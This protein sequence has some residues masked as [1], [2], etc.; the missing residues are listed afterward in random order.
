MSK[1]E[2]V[3]LT[4]VCRGFPEAPDPEIRREHLLDTIDKVFEGDTRLVVVEG[5]EGIGKTT[6]LAQFAKRHPENALSLF[7]KPCSRLAYSP[8]YLTVVLSEQL[9]WV[10]HKEILNEETVDQ[11]FL[12]NQFPILQRRA[13]RNREKYFFIVDGLAD[14]PSEDDRLKDIVLKDLLPLGLPG[15]YFLL[16]G[17]LR[18]FSGKI[19]RSIL[20][21]SFPL[22]PF[23]FDDTEKY[24]LDLELDRPS[25]EETYKMCGGVPGHLAIVRRMIQSG[26]DL[27][28]ILDFVP[29]KLP[30]F[31][32]IEWSKVNADE[33][34]KK[35]LAV[36]AYAQKR[37]TVDELSR[38]LGM[39]TTA[40]G[41]FLRSLGIVTIQSQDGEVCFIS[42][43]HRKY[44]ANQLQ[45]L[46]EQA[47][48][49]L[50]SDL[51]GQKESDAAITG[52]IPR[53]LLRRIYFL[54]EVRHSRMLLAG[55]Q[56]KLGLDPR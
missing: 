20:S 50:I 13:L 2:V 23:S 41:S 7:I 18:D 19:H 53:S 9:Y 56:A 8:E 34:Q 1:P 52:L 49:L 48:N 25:L 36:I 3:D 38:I 16:A 14:I 10:L 31:L 51:V 39:S 44:A 29:D 45:E 42:E 21:K 28:N 30:D 47:S 46:K 6:L 33:Q 11:A 55:I 26:T 40:I 43:A 24:L 4:V 15:F 27:Q 12:R 17:D 22:S 35:L 37:Y 32:A 5:A 54:S